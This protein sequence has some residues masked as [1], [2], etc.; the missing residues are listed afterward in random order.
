M[1]LDWET[2]LKLTIEALIDDL[3]W[4]LAVV[5]TQNDDIEIIKSVVAELYQQAINDV[6][7]LDMTVHEY[8]FTVLDE[9][10]VYMKPANYFESEEEAEK[11]GFY[12][13]DEIDRWL[14]L[15]ANSPSI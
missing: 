13:E 9:E 14:K 8:L 3:T 10:E 1:K 15:D 12:W 11:Q 4:N 2:A 6:D 5:F 7:G